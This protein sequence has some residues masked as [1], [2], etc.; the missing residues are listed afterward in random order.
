MKRRGLFTKLLLGA[1][2][3]PS[4]A[5][6]AVESAPTGLEVYDHVWEGE[7]IPALSDAE[8]ALL[9]NRSATGGLISGREAQRLYNRK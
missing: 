3:I 6:A 5:K 7:Y 9:R 4:I 1:V 8:F 2:A